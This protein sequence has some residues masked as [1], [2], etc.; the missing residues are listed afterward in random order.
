VHLNPAFQWTGVAGAS[1]YEIQIADNAN[2]DDIISALVNTTAW[3]SDTTLEYG[4][5]YYWRV[6]ALNSNAGSDW[7]TGVFTTR[8]MPGE[9][10]SENQQWFDPKSGLYFE[11]EEDLIKYQTAHQEDLGD[12]VSTPAYI[13]VIIAVGGMLVIIMVVLIFKARSL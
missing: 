8:E 12:A 6:R 1:E 11:T 3:V 9:T 7:V 2:F 5:T 13:W 10:A 4:T